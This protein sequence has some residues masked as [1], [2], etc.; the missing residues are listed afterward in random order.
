MDLTLADKMLKKTRLDLQKTF[1][2]T[3]CV[4]QILGGLSLRLGIPREHGLAFRQDL[5]KV[6]K[7]LVDW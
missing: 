7:T 4:S 2:D 5:E 1:P 3:P 6:G